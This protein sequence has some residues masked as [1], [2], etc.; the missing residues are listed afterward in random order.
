MQPTL[1]AAPKDFYL[2]KLWIFRKRK[3]RASKLSFFVNSTGQVKE[4]FA[5]FAKIRRL[6]PGEK[7]NLPSCSCDS[8]GNL[9]R[10]RRVLYDRSK[11]FWTSPLESCEVSSF[12]EEVYYKYSKRSGELV[13][14]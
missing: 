9:I 7:S 6:K 10:G 3:H 14:L 11:H 8:D 2:E 5:C 13:I 4:M 1:F 12:A